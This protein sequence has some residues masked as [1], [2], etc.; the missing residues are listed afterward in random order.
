[1][2]TSTEY[3]K[4]QMIAYNNLNRDRLKIYR[5]EY[6]HKRRKEDPVWRHRRNIFT[7]INYAILY[8]GDSWGPASRLNRIVGIDFQTFKIYIESTMEETMSWENRSSWQLDHII[9]VSTA[10]TIEEVEKLFFF[11]NLRA[12]TPED[13]RKRN[14][15]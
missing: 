5:N 2:K 14:N 6:A 9:E 1:M 3:R 7:Q 11:K 8:N 12:L 4:A 13:N 10:T 15:N